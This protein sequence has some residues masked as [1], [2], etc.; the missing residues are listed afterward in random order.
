M[1][2]LEP[3]LGE[4]KRGV[5]DCFGVPYWED[6]GERSE[7]GWWV[8]VGGRGVSTTVSAASGDLNRDQC[9]QS[10]RA[11]ETSV[12]TYSVASKGPR[13]DRRCRFPTNRAPRLARAK[14]HEI[15][16]AGKKVKKP[17]EDE[18][19]LLLKALT[20]PYPLLNDCK[21]PVY[22]VA[23]RIIDAAKRQFGPYEEMHIEDNRKQVNV[24]HRQRSF[25][26]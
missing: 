4:G 6:V 10:T 14:S 1:E 24:T 22:F 2:R 8:I 23:R 19:H 20:F 12:M 25:F 18:R 11:T 3:G 5:R 21:D 13:V 16:R 9:R 7:E 26:H 15:S 17:P